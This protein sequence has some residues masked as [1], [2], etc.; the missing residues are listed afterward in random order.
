MTRTIWDISADMAALESLLWES[1]GEITP[2]VDQAI[3]AWE[4]EIQGDLHGKLENY[5]RL[6]HELE[7]RSKARAEEAKRIAALAKA[8][9]TAAEN[10]RERLRLLW[11]ARALG[12]IDTPNFRFS[13]A[14]NGGKAPL[15]I[16]GDI[17]SMPVWAV[18]R[19]TLVYPDKDAIRARLEA[20]EQLE[21]ATLMERGNRISIK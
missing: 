16:H 8:D 1:G 10:L 17:E 18:K 14:R 2:Q 21:F 11:E 4:A 3:T 7:A 12:K 5:A 13:L 20:G 19:E 15:D 9:A 6:I